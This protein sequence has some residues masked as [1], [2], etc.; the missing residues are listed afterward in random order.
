MYLPTLRTGVFGA[1]LVLALGLMFLLP[2]ST[3]AAP[4]DGCDRHTHGNVTMGC[5]NAP[6]VYG[7]GENAY[8][9]GSAV[10]EASPQNDELRALTTGNEVCKSGTP[11]E[12]WKSERTKYN[13]RITSA[14]GGPSNWIPSA[15][16]EPRFGIGVTMRLRAP[17][18][19]GAPALSDIQIG[20]GGKRI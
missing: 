5:A 6:N 9:R 16:Q 3:L 15:C 2:H 19:I 14:S 10:V 17:I 7:S 20:S 11:V 8:A 18:T 12:I 1:V 13:A 4:P